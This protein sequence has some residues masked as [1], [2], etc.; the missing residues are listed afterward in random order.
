MRIEIA[1]IFKGIGSRLFIFGEN[2]EIKE[3]RQVN[4]DCLLEREREKGNWRIAKT[5]ACIQGSG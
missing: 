3:L 5:F 2:K 4:S 1:F